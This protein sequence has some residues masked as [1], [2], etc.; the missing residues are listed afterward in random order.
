MTP[1]GISATSS[2]YLTY[3]GKPPETWRALPAKVTWAR[4][5]WHRLFSCFSIYPQPCAL[6]KF[7]FSI[8]PGVFVDSD[9]FGIQVLTWY[10]HDFSSVESR[11]SPHRPTAAQMACLWGWVSRENLKVGNRG[12]T[13]FT[14]GSKV[15]S[16]LPFTPDPGDRVARNARD[17]KTTGPIPASLAALASLVGCTIVSPEPCRPFSTQLLPPFMINSSKDIQESTSVM[18][19]RGK[20]QSSITDRGIS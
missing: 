6:Q 20:G 13:G 16:T 5:L 12:N 7:G 15:L 14:Q 1:K 10:P 3:F 18:D 2:E 17:A 8:L 4:C 19:L 11:K 9:L